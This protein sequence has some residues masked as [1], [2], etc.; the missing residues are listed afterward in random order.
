VKIAVETLPFEVYTPFRTRLEPFAK[1]FRMGK[2]YQILATWIKFTDC[3]AEIINSDF[4]DRHDQVGD[5]SIPDLDEP[6]TG[7]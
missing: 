4:V 7:A 6:P 5:A 1:H 2:K 3:S